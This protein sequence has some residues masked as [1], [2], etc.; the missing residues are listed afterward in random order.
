L[1]VAE[2]AAAHQIVDIAVVLAIEG[3]KIGSQF[4]AKAAGDIEA[5]IIIARVPPH[6][7]VTQRRLAAQVKTGVGG[8]H[9]DQAAGGVAAKCRA[10]RSAQ[11]FHALD[12]DEIDPV[13]GRLWLVDTIDIG[14]DVWLVADRD[15][16][17]PDAA[18]DGLEDT[19]VAAP[20][21]SGNHLGQ[22]AHRR[23]ICR[24][25]RIAG[26]RGHGDSNVLQTLLAARGRHD[27][28][29]D[30]RTR[31]RLGLGFGSRG[32][33]LGLAGRAPGQCEKCD[34]AREGA[35]AIITVGPHVHSPSP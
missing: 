5:G 17:R 18:N 10:L 13:G 23:N 19:H 28:V 27:D 2:R 21:E 9:V 35:P 31:L 7:A 8:N 25:E 33:I 1:L 16:G 32:R 12:F 24:R 15:A 30:T 4:I 26:D 11:H 34:A 20:D 14:G 22:R 6:A 29:G 3:G